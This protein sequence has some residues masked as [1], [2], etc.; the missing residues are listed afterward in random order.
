VRRKRDMWPW[1]PG[2]MRP[3]LI[4]SSMGTLVMVAAFYPFLGLHAL[5]F[6]L[7]CLIGPLIGLVYGAVGKKVESLKQALAAEE[8]IKTECL[9]V[10]DRTQSPGIAILTESTLRLVPIMGDSRSIDRKSIDSIRMVRMFNGKLLVWK[11]W[12]V[13]SIKPRL[14]FALPGSTVAE[15]YERLSGVN[16]W[17]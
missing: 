11:R 3:I 12:L 6:L 5:Y 9:I 13:L 17:S 2:L 10:I 1:N 8:G 4:G 7:L 14:G 16:K 15:W